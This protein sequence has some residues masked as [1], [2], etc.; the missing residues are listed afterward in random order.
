MAD[1]SSISRGPFGRNGD[2]RGVDDA[3]ASERRHIERRKAG[4]DWIKLFHN[5]DL[6]AVNEALRDCEVMV[7]PAGTPLLTPGQANRDVYILLS[8][9]MSAYLGA[10]VNP[11]AEIP[12]SVGECIGEFSAID[13]QPVSALVMARA[14]V[15][16]L[17]LSAE[18]FWNRLMA[19]PGIASNLMVGLIER[20]RRANQQALRAQREQLELVHLRKELDVAHQLQTGMLPMQRPLFPD[21]TDI[22]ICGFMEPASLVG[23]DLFD[24]FFI[25]ESRLFFC[26]GDVSGHGIAAALF[27]ARTIGLLRILATTIAEPDALLCTLN[28]RLCISNDANIFVTLFCGVLDIPSGEVTYSNGGHC[29]PVLI[30][31]HSAGMLP[32]PRGP[33]IGAFPGMKY[34]PMR[35]HLEPGQTLFCYTDG[36]TEA[37]NAQKEEYSEERF[38]EFLKGAAAQPLPDLVE[39]VRDQVGQFTGSQQLIE[40]DCTM[41]AVRLPRRAS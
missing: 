30:D 40:D 27:M 39:A 22:E 12:I 31:D 16:V 21:R 14:E 7:L 38:V 11:L 33:L 28:D 23:G 19:I 6:N 35:H 2:R 25:D 1:D 3:A 15:R 10:D 32:I 34:L 5:A 4:V 8:G 41:L 29:A 18:V 13:G 9:D 26:I 20:T 24:A 36:V 17:R 37:Q